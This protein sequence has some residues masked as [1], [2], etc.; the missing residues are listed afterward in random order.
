LKAADLLSDRELD[1]SRAQFTSGYLKRSALE[2]ERDV[3]K[4]DVIHWGIDIGKFR[5]SDEKADRPKLLYVGQL[6][7]QKGIRTAVEALK[8]II[9]QPGL[10][11]TTLTIVRGPDYGDQVHRLVAS[12]GLELNIRFTGLVSRD[13]LPAIYREH[14]ILLF[15]SVWDEP[16]SLT[17]LEAMSSGLAVVGTNTGGSSEILEDTINALVFPKQDAEE[18]AVQVIRLLQ[19]RELRETIGRNARN[20]VEQNFRLDAMVDRVDRALRHARQ[21]L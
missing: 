19:A 4:A 11:S 8:L 14:Q 9:Q 7:S 16:F 6:T 13:R 3:S 10:E 17:L 12:L 18:C 5:F 1:L 21:T 2:A 20:T 15:P